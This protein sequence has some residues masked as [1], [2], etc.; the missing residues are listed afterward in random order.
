MTLLGQ[1]VNSYFFKPR[2]QTEDDS[3]VGSPVTT[4][5]FLA[6]GFRNMFDSK[7]RKGAGI[8]FHN[9]LEQI[10]LVDPELRIR[11][12]SPHPKDFTDE[13]IDVIAKHPNVCKGIHLPA[14]S[15]SSRMLENMRRYHTKEA[16][17]DLVTRM[18]KQIPDVELSSDFIVGFCGETEADHR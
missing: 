9:L 7:S 12:T 3:L 4:D 16:Y 15:G 10:A 8:R 14:Q 11:F 1:N 13:V 6:H 18:R 17:M 5:D 2:S